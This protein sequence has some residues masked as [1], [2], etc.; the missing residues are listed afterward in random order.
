[1]STMTDMM[2]HREA[3]LLEYA[4]DAQADTLQIRRSEKDIF[5]NIE[6]PK[7]VDEYADKLKEAQG[8]LSTDLEKLKG[9]ATSA[10]VQ[11]RLKEMTEDFQTYQGGMSS[12][13]GRVK[14][15]TIS[16]PAD[17]NKAI[18]E[19]KD[20]IHRLEKNASE[21]A[22]EAVGQMAKIVPQVES[23]ERST[24]WW[25]GIFTCV[26][27]AVGLGLSLMLGRTISGP[28]KQVA[29]RLQ[30]IAQGEGDLTRRLEMTSKDEIGDV[31]HWFNVFIEKLQRIIRSVGT[32]TQSLAGSAEELTV[33]SQQMAGNA[34][35]TSAQSGVVSAAS[36]QVSKNVQTV[37]A[38]ADEMSA[39]I[40]EIAQSATQAA[41]VAKQAVEVAEQTNQTIT[42]LGESSAEIGDVI[43]VI[44]S[45][46]EQTNL[47]ALNA[48]IEAA[49]AGEAGKGFA[50]VANEVKELAKQTGQ[51]TED[52][53]QKISAI[54]LDTQGA[55]VAIQQIG[56]IVNQ[57][58]DISNTIASAVEE[59]SVTTN[60]MSRNVG[61]A[62]TA[63]HEIVQNIAGV[64]Q[65]AQSTASGATE[66]QT[67]AQELAR[68]ATELQTAISQFKV[69][70][71]SHDTKSGVRVK[72][73][74]PKHPGIKPQPTYQPVSSTLHTL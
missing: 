45:I 62:A 29:D 14:T 68:L 37:A 58:N 32:N 48:T 61:E 10:E 26:A 24:A 73:K 70:A 65:A 5:L 69:D 43:K 34:E 18:A 2:M 39:S 51:A 21:L 56:G 16:T 12:V 30:D 8:K 42:K 60:E 23:L 41:H 7:K 11:K 38:G 27:V 59:Q 57:I 72:E 40:K 55:V 22:D 35:E 17:G 36:E 66:T 1:M 13:F 64:A 19:H 50:V 9:I 49:R 71:E 54:Q 31:A 28:L 44:T 52:I 4:D 20:A 47:L 53:T 3:K 63:T 6:D 33:V 46:A 25:M 15:G 67:A 74:A